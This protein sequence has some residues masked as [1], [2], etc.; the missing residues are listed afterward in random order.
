MSK[1]GSGTKGNRTPR[2]RGGERERCD[3]RRKRV[4]KR[5]WMN[6]TRVSPNRNDREKQQPTDSFAP[7]ILVHGYVLRPNR[8]LCARVF[9]RVNPYVFRE[10]SRS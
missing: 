6:S 4:A 2:K 3:N 5:G 1:Y 9:T 10:R 7:V 8:V